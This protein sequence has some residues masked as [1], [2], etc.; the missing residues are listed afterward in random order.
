MLYYEDP[1]LK[2]ALKPQHQKTLSESSA[3]MRSHES[4]PAGL[5]YLDLLEPSNY[6]PGSPIRLYKHTHLPV[7][8]TS[9]LFEGGFRAPLKGV[10]WEPNTP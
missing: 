3:S 5:L 8:I 4:A 10:P 2:G 6:N 7:S 1:P 9:G